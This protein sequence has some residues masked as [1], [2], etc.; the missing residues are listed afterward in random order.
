[1]RTIDFSPI[2]RSSVGFDHLASLLDATARSDQNQGGFPPYDIVLLE[3][4]KYRIT[5]AVAGF[6]Q[7][8]I[9]ITSENDTLT[10]T[11]QQGSEDDQK[12]LYQG[13]AKRGFERKF[14]IADHVK[15][16]N[17]NLEDG[18]L[19]I[20]LEREVPEAL[21]PRKITIGSGLGAKL[22]H[23]DSSKVA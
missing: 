15:V 20:S 11:G 5:M 21:K 1:M 2:F 23:E 9:D 19:H 3:E 10:V 22:L 13:I 8:D 6:K 4:D 7:S 14:K 16:V 17:A 12:Y 18:L